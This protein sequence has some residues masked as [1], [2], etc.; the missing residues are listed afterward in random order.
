[1]KLSHFPVL[2]L[3]L[4]CFTAKA[5]DSSHA[6][7]SR[8]VR[9]IV[10]YPPGGTSDVLA[11]ALQ[12][13]FQRITGQPLIVE[14]R[15]GASG[16]VATADFVHAKPDGYTLLFPNNSMTIS[17]NFQKTPSY[18]P[19]KDFT[20]IALVAT[21]P[22]LLL[23]HPSVPATNV[24]QFLAHAK[25]HRLP[26]SSSGGGA[27]GRLASE[28]F[29]DMAGIETLH[30]PYKGS[31][32]STLAVLT[33]EVKWTFTTPSAAI[34]GHVEAGKLRLIGIA[35]EKPSPVVPGGFPIGTVLP[36]FSSEVWFGILAPAKI[37]PEIEASLEQ[38][39]ARILR[40][41]GIGE[42]FVASGAVVARPQ[43]TDF[44]KLISADVQK[45]SK[46]IKQKGIKE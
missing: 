46:L 9:L 26:F 35:S 29:A 38:T 30:V 25:Q 17:G 28:L 1:M 20:P 23:T 34:F 24:D 21:T 8:A 4:A 40:E 13:P 36:G 32:P 12:E 16:D 15:A 3:M 42:K 5:Q 41:P 14:N 33:G 27:A 11:R 2:L 44:R 31:A 18:D 7:P 37:P 22:L 43:S 19:V 10:P 45:W 6:F 39:F